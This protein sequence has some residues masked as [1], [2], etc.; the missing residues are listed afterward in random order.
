MGASDVLRCS[1]R[2]RRQAV[3][4]WREEV[5]SKTMGK[6]P[7]RMAFLPGPPQ[8]RKQLPWDQDILRQTGMFRPAGAGGSRGLA[9]AKSA[10][11][12][13]CR[14][15]GTSGIAGSLNVCGRWNAGRPR[16]GNASGVPRPRDAGGTR[17][18]NASVGN[19]IFP[20]RTG[21]KVTK[22]LVRKRPPRFPRGHAATTISPKSS[23]IV[24]GVMSRLVNL[25]VPPRTTAA[26]PA[27]RRCVRSKTV[28]GSTWPARPKRD[29]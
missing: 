15:S 7:R 11:G 22:R 10:A 8:G 5:E 18:Q 12:G 23:A 3:A 26:M 17:R 21:P 2:V 29:G 25:L 19:G 16:N 4:E 13:F 6:C 14:G 1:P 9:F 28:S 27:V 20:K 24:P